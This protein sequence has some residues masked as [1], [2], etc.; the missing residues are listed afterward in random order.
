[1]V[2]WTEAELAGLTGEVR[3]LNFSIMCREEKPIRSKVFQMMEE[4]IPAMN[5]LIHQREMSYMPK[6]PE[7]KKTHRILAKDTNTCHQDEQL[8]CKNLRFYFRQT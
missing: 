8:G 1:M 5:F 6:Q 7:R 2:S 3:G 4:I